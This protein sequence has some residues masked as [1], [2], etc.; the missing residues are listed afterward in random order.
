MRKTTLKSLLIL[1]CIGVSSILYSQNVAINTSGNSA[2]VSA[3]LDLSNHNTAGTVGLLPPYVNLNLPLTS[4]QLSGTAA[5]SNGIII[6]A[7]GAGTA[8]AGLYY[9]N[10]TG[11]TWVSMAGGAGGPLSGS[12]TLN[13]LARWTPNGTTLG[14]GV[15]QD[16]GIGMGISP[17]AITPVST[18]DV[19]GNVSIG[20][21]AGNNAA[22]A[23]GAIIS[24]Q[25]GIG[26]NAPNAAAALDVTS[27]TQGLLIP[28]LAANPAGTATSLM[29][30]NT[31]TNCFMFYNGTSW[32]NIV[33]T[34]NG[35]PPAPATPSNLT[36][37]GNNTLL[38]NTNT[39]QYSVPAVA[40]ATSY[41]WYSSN[42]AVAIVQASTPT[43]TVTITTA[44]VA[45]LSTFNLSVSATNS[46][47]SSVA[48]TSVMITVVPAVEIFTYVAGNQT[49]TVPCGATTA[50]IYLWGG[51]GGGGAG[52]GTGPDFV[53]GGGGGGGACV[54]ATPAVA[55]GAAVTITTGAG[56]AAGTTSPTNG[57]LG[58]TTTLVIGATTWTAAGGAGGLTQTNTNTGI[59][60]AGGAGGSTGTGPGITIYSGGGGSKGYN[61]TNAANG[62]TGTGGGGG[63]SAGNGAAVANG[64]C[65]GTAAGGAGVY[66]GGAGQFNTNCGTTTSSTGTNGSA[67]G[68]GGSG[69]NDWAGGW[70]GSSGGAGQV[71]IVW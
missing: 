16:N 59:N 12:G 28:R 10:N 69:D 36:C 32:Q 47:G 24:G 21:Y 3:I 11:S 42:N 46:C 13:Y 15:A 8:P 23:N 66:P 31:T 30:F 4:F 25:V 48:S 9:W 67:P 2:Y 60:I 7:T 37:A 27:T 62:Y 33:C 38:A 34:C 14:T 58:G 70:N 61:G 57:G 40:G 68:G 29:Y 53:N 41:Q 56:G 20:T 6:Y 35:I 44:N 71:I 19:N 51:G 49:T 45:S 17:S 52:V 54:K 26:T 39:V 5:Q 63:G 55:S 18:L 50:T 64:I 22:P 43:P 1:L 65:S